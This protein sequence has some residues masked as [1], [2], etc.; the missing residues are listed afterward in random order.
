MP[1]RSP[2]VMVLEAAKARPMSRWTVQGRHRLAQ[3]LGAIRHWKVRCG[4]YTKAPD[5]E[6][7]WFIDPPYQKGG[8]HYPAGQPDYGDLA[9]WCRKRR[10]QVIVCEGDGAEWLPFRHL[11]GARRK[12]TVAGFGDKQ[13]IERVWE[14]GPGRQEQLFEGS[15]EAP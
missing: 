4:D 6:A 11:R 15:T 5:I 10:G 7:T 14:Q 3:Q 12:N 8:E 9:A 1:S 2:T 13:R